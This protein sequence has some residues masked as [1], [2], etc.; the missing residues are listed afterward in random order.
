MAAAEEADR[1]MQDAWADEAKPLDHLPTP[2]QAALALG[3]LAKQYNA[4]VHEYRKLQKVAAAARADAIKAEATAFLT[5]D[6][7]MDKRKWE[8]RESAADD[9]WQADLAER[10]VLAQREML[11][12]LEIRIEVGRTVAA[13]AREEYRGLPGEGTGS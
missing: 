1:S 7:A 3:G 8:A 2:V 4:M 9:L 11:R 13:T 12:A 10:M 5:A 6:G